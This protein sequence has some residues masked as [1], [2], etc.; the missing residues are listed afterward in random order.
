MDPI[1]NKPSKEEILNDV[2]CLY[3]CSMGGS[4]VTKEYKKN[5]AITYIEKLNSLRFGLFFSSNS[6]PESKKCFRKMQSITR[7]SS[8]KVQKCKL[9]KKSAECILKVA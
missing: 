3:G 7:K 1:V 9:D 5:V 2:T 8:P 4:I 6:T